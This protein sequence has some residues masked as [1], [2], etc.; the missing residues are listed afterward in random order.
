MHISAT[1][2]QITFFSFTVAA[3]PTEIFGKKCVNDYCDAAML[4]FALEIESQ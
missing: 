3:L 4:K 2:N 1:E